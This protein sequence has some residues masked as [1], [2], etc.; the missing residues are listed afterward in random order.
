MGN[1]TPKADVLE[2]VKRDSETEALIDRCVQMY[3]SITMAATFVNAHEQAIV[4][5]YVAAKLPLPFPEDRRAALVESNAQL[6]LIMYTLRGIGLSEDEM[7]ARFQACYH[8]RYFPTDPRY[9]PRRPTLARLAEKGY[10]L[11]SRFFGRLG[12]KWR[13]RPKGGQRDLYQ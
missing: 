2:P 1:D 3:T 11:L 4:D 7:T 9:A 10:S 8:E 12:W 13:A 5:L 6:S